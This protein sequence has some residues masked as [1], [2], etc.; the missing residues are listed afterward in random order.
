MSE[1][2]PS[3]ARPPLEPLPVPMPRIIEVGLGLWLVALVVILLVPALH[4]G[5]RSWW[6][7]GAVAGL[8]LGLIG[9]AYVRR[10]RGN[11]SE[12]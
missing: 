6:P 12:A 2:Q 1:Q 3:E 10:G 8:A 7:W 4:E 9:Y 11:A 5:S